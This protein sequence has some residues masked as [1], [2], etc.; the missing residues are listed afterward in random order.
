MCMFGDFTRVFRR[1]IVIVGSSIYMIMGIYMI[2]VLDKKHLLTNTSL[3]GSVGLRWVEQSSLFCL[4]LI[5]Q[6]IDG[7]SEIES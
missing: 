1:A 7:L 5:L 4:I 6:I 3:S 2:M